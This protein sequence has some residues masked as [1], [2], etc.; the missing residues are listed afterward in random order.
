MALRTP[1][2]RRRWLSRVARGGF[3]RRALDLCAGIGGF[4][5]G[6]YQAGFRP[7]GV[8]IDP[9]AVAI[10]RQHVGVCVEADVRRLLVGDQPVDL[11][12]ADLPIESSDR[13][14]VQPYDRLETHPAS[15]PHQ[16]VRIARQ[17]EAGA[18]LL[19]WYPGP[20]KGWRSRPA[21]IDRLWGLLDAHGFSPAA[22][23]L[24]AV[25]YGV[26]QHRRRWI[27]L[28][29]ASKGLRAAFR[30]PHPTHVPARE[31][32][33]RKKPRY[34]TP[35]DVLG[36]PIDVPAPPI[37]ASEHKAAWRGDRGGRARLRRASEHLAVQAG[38]GAWGAHVPLTVPQLAVLQGLPR[39]WRFDAMR[40]D[41]QYRL[42]GHAFPPAFAEVLA[43]RIR[44]AFRATGWAP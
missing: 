1:R 25:D 12:V 4:S 16:I 43:R 24:D 2:L 34:V 40:R 28:G 21:A 35:R 26:P 42:V 32:H 44:R 11:V 27:V 9:D 23:V 8:E 22:R 3:G 29:F 37:T 18:V 30:W 41:V 36:L 10:Y 33:D 7:Y 14:G 19:V 31:A 39:E 6:L 5:S 38:R 15:L 13:R 20:S 17:V